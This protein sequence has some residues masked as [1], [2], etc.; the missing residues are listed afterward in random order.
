M[1]GVL[2]DGAA[3]RHALRASWN[4]NETPLE[5]LRAVR[6]IDYKGEDSAPILLSELIGQLTVGP[7]PSVLLLQYLRSACAVGAVPLP[8]LLGA[9]ASLLDT[10]HPRVVS[11]LLP[12]ARDALKAPIPGAL[13]AQKES[14]AYLNDWGVALLRLCGASLSLSLRALSSSDTDALSVENAFRAIALVTDRVLS[15]RVAVVMLLSYDAP[16]RA[17]LETQCTAALAQSDF[18]N[19]LAVSVRDLA[20]R[21]FRFFNSRALPL[22]DARRDR[23][24][25]GPQT[26]AMSPPRLPS[27]AALEFALAA[28]SPSAPFVSDDERATQL[29][30]LALSVGTSA[31]LLCVDLCTAALVGM[32]RAARIT[33]MSTR[34]PPYDTWRALFLR[35]LPRWFAGSLSQDEIANIVRS[36]GRMQELILAAYM[37]DSLGVLEEALRGIEIDTEP[38]DN[39]MSADDF[40]AVNARG[41][42]ALVA[43]LDRAD[44]SLSPERLSSIAESLLASPAAMDA[45][46]LSGRGDALLQMLSVGASTAC[47]L[48]AVA[49]LRRTG[50]ATCDLLDPAAAMLLREL[51]WPRGLTL[52]GDEEEDVESSAADELLSGRIVRSTDPRRVLIGVRAALYSAAISDDVSVVNSAAAAIAA[53]CMTPDTL[54]LGALVMVA[55][56]SESRASPPGTWDPPSSPGASVVQEA[57][58][59]ATASAHQIV[60]SV[61]LSGDAAPSADALAQLGTV[62]ASLEHGESIW[63]AADDLARVLARVGRRAFLATLWA[64]AAEA[65]NADATRGARCAGALAALIGSPLHRDAGLAAFFWRETVPSA[66]AA[67]ATLTQVRVLAE[68]AAAVAVRCAPIMR[69]GKATEA[70]EAFSALVDWLGRRQG[71]APASAAMLQRA[72]MNACFVSY[73]VGPWV[74]VAAA[75][76]CEGFEAVLGRLGDD[77]RCAAAG[78]LLAAARGGEGRGV[79]EREELR[80]TAERLLAAT[81]QF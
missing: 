40:V 44:N 63:G 74:A 59:Q 39:E 68:A 56:S 60:F 7:T 57:L 4:A 3:V 45:V 13:W 15:R 24:T 41:T 23:W 31:E 65:V 66:L 62:F 49:F 1:P 14:A 64:A 37:H 70:R 35:R 71:D 32:A 6:S 67:C 80:G 46:A 36:L 27:P 55:L 33:D 81:L 5:F 38:V 52:D 58:Q 42:S 28:V 22:P 30:A 19:E 79:F 51:T 61:V 48:A 69:A 12:I 21:L 11:A 76:W 26:T 72:E 18:S 2:Q 20:S 77:D 54:V 75:T 50:T 16:E 43:L 29:A 78:V 53:L 10:A 25:A 9:F 34:F 8:L 73:F 17:F 47:A